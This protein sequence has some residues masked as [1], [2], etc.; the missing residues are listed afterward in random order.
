MQKNRRFA[1]SV[2]DVIPLSSRSEKTR[3]MKLPACELN[4]LC[5]SSSVI[6]LA[7]IAAALMLS[8]TTISTNVSAHSYKVGEIAVG[9]IW[10]PPPTEDADGLPIYGAILNNGNE[11]ARLRAASVSVAN[12]VKF[13][14]ID[15]DVVS[16]PADIVFLPNKPLA[17]APWREHIWIAGLRRPISE[18]DTFEL[19][20]DFGPSGQLTVTVIVE[21]NEGH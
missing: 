2:Q 1:S 19:S 16:W 9:H 20:L 17:L 21:P 14:R 10:A 7:L 18:G 12:D 11:A 3:R 5:A 13:R 6:R 15:G 4:R 8:A